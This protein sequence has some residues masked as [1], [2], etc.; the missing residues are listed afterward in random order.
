[1]KLS[2]EHMPSVQKKCV[3]Y[4]SRN[5]C[6]HTHT[7]VRVHAH[8]YKTATIGF[9]VQ[10]A[11]EGALTPPHPCTA[12]GSQG[13]LWNPAGPLVFQGQAASYRD[14][15]CPRPS[16]HS[17]TDHHPGRVLSSH[18][19]CP[20]PGPVFG[21][22]P[23]AGRSSFPAVGS[24]L[25]SPPWTSKRRQHC[26]VRPWASGLPV[27]PSPVPQTLSTWPWSPPQ[28]GVA[29]ALTGH[30]HILPAGPGQGTP[31]S[32]GAL[33]ARWGRSSAPL[34]RA[35]DSALRRRQRPLAAAAPELPGQP[36]RLLVLRTAGCAGEAQSSFLP[37]PKPR[38]PSFPGGPGPQQGRK[39]GRAEVLLAAPSLVPT[40]SSTRPAPAHTWLSW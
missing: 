24:L 26:P 10:V 27:F 1:M 5:K 14:G 18:L 39:R 23:A 3:S 33:S 9:L 4:M 11:L 31:L 21:A 12:A 38:P 20:E 28:G 30:V 22:A 37:G 17:A 36:P 8:R 13:L 15:C 34:G 7:P 2:V 19:F 29:S 6:R 35:A 16:G 40:L 25:P 32:T